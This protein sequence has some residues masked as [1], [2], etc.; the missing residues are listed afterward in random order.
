M[1]DLA[2]NAP[3]L[4]AGVVYYGSQP[5]ASDVEKIKAPLLLQYAGQ[6]ARINEGIRRSKRRSRKPTRHTLY[7]ST[8]VPSTPSTTIR[9]RRAIANQ[10]PNRRGRARSPSRNT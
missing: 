8:K 10:R 6:D 2:V 1:G 3:D 5:K 9:P 4:D 7:T